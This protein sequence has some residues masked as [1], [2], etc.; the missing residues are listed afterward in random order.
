VGREIERTWLGLFF[1][2][3][4]NGFLC[5][6]LTLMFIRERQ[7]K[8]INGWLMPEKTGEKCRKNNKPRTENNEPDATI[9]PDEIKPRR[10]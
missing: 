9:F 8:P 3:L 1:Y 4:T 5:L 6:S 2:S 10:S 7:R